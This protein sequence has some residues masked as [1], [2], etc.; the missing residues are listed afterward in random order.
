MGMRY[1]VRIEPGEGTPRTFQNSRPISV[2]SLIISGAALIGAATADTVKGRCFGVNGCKG[3][4]ACKSAHNDCGQNA[5]KDQ[6]WF[7][8]IE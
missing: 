4:G 8:M 7:S 1:I 6:G 2:R 5:C 3:Q